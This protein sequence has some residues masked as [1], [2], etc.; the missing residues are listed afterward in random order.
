MAVDRL[1]G[2]PSRVLLVTA[3]GHLVLAL[4]CGAW[5]LDEEPAILGLHPA[6]KPAKFAISIAVFLGTIA[7]LLPAL[8]LQPRARLR[9][10]WVLSAT[11]ILEM[12]SIVAQALRGTRSHF[13]IDGTLN[14][15]TWQSMVAAIAVMTIV[16]TWVAFV[17]TQRPLLDR[18]RQPLPPLL[19][20]AWRAGLWIFLLSAVSGFTMGGQLQHSVGGD[21]G[22]PGLPLLNWSSTHGDLRVSHFFSL[23]ALQ[24]LPLTA[25]AVA[26]LPLRQGSRLGILRSIAWLYFGACAGTLVQAVLG[27]SLL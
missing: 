1:S 6:L 10:A 4:A 14:F 13:N 17:A 23:H 15:W 16:M 19:R 11:M 26:R 27:R 8:S 5:L 21:D 22:G 18:E 25:L 12:L 7:L 3:S 2:S 24:L 9:L 20:F